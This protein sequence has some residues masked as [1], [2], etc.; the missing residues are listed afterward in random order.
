MRA[1]IT[2][3]T[4]TVVL[5]VA[6]AAHAETPDEI[7]GALA[8]NQTHSWID[9]GIGFDQMMI[10]YRAGDRLYVTCGNVAEIARRLLRDAGYPA[11]VVQTL[12]LGE[13]DEISDGH[14]MTELFAD[15]R[16]QLYDLDANV[17]AVDESDRGLSVLEQAQAVQ[18][19]RALW[20]PIADDPLYRDDEPDPVLRDLAIRIF[21]APEAFYEHVMGV[22][23]LPRDSAGTV[24][25]GMYFH[26]PA[27]IE[28]LAAYKHGWRFV[29][30]D[31]IWQRLTM[32]SDPPPA[33]TPVAPKPAVPVLVTPPAVP[34]ATSPQ[35]EQPRRSCQHLKRRYRRTHSRSDRRRYARCRALRASERRS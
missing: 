35:V 29:A 18:E 12:T 8:A 26:D 22:P 13:F 21:T 24:N 19:H 28:R 14:L 11:R 34:A 2:A 25:E 10:R 32:T 3:L 23:L 5:T 15:G 33:P 27:Q 7:V 6:P 9:D 4:L 30:D 31:A 16:W 1:T 20:E 17:R